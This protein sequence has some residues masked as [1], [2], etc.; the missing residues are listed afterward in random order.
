[1][2]KIYNFILKAF[3]PVLEF[4][5]GKHAPYT[6]K[7]IT[8][9][10]Y[11]QW[12]DKISVG[13][14]ILTTTRGELTNIFN[15]VKIKHSGIYVGKIL[16]DD[17]CYIAE[18]TRNGVILTDLVTFLTTK[19]IA[20]G[21]KP[22]FIV[23]DNQKFGIQEKALNYIGK[24]YDYYFEKNKDEM[25][26]FE[27]CFHCLGNAHLKSREIVKGKCI[28]DHNTFLDDLHFNIIFDSRSENG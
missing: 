28:F 5:S 23:T 25:Y 21:C 18:S 13:T 11:Y 22:K 6:H 1:M 17:I 16:N 15:P 3:K 4:I 10:Q 27:L 8:G 7:K 14:V 19:D 2:N 24:K 20:I 12:R 26:C 9:K